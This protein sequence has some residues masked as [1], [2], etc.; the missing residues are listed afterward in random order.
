[1]IADTGD[2]DVLQF[3]TL[4]KDLYRWVPMDTALPGK[5]VMH[6]GGVSFIPLGE[7]AGQ[8]QINR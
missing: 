7:N 3:G 2:G 5:P 4:N 1:M 6:Y 8:D